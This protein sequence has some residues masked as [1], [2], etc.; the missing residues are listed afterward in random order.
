MLKWKMITFFKLCTF[1]MVLLLSN[2]HAGENLDKN[3]IIKIV[4]EL[5]RQRDA[6]SKEIEKLQDLL[7]ADSELD[8]LKTL[9]AKATMPERLR[10]RIADGIRAYSK[11]DFEKA[12]DDFQMA[13]EIDS[14]NSITNYN[15]GLAYYQLNNFPLAKRMLHV[16][17]KGDPKISQVEKINEFLLGKKALS[18]KPE[19]LS[20]EETRLH[21]ELVNLKNE[22][23]SYL[24]AKNLSSFIR[25]KSTV[26]TLEKILEKAKDHDKLVQEFY[27][28]VA[29]TL[30]LYDMFDKALDVLQIYE[31]SMVGK[32]LPENYHRKKLHV[33]EKLAAQRKMLEGYENA[34]TD[35]NIRQLLTRDLR[36]LGIFSE[37]L[38]E[39]VVS[40]DSNDEDFSK[41]C[42]RLR[43]YRWGNKSGRHVIVVNRFQ[44]LL[45]SSLPGTLPLNRYRDNEG[46]SFLKDITLLPGELNGKEAKFFPVNLNVNGEIV[47]YVVMYTYAPK[48]KAF[49]IVRLPKKDLT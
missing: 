48:H 3:R 19:K 29:D 22:A 44:E 14:E 8:D 20:T 17:V 43:E 4:D 33:E 15:L 27:L 7:G 28:P 46:R 34:E 35:P 45:Y 11:G 37:Q 9:E 36:E 32:V 2:V 31:K 38:E 39:F 26:S 16:A 30:S 12:K 18:K 13:W 41:I 49:I 6:L 25:M 42:R 24:K 10:I 5:A 40:A 23:E 21:T 1:A 47:P